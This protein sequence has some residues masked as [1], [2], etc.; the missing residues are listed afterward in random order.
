MKRIRRSGIIFR[1]AADLKVSHFRKLAALFSKTDCIC[2]IPVLFAS[3]SILAACSPYL[4]R[5]SAAVRTSHSI[6]TTTT[7]Q[8]DFKSSFRSVQPWSVPSSEQRSSLPASGC[9]RRRSPLRGCSKPSQPFAIAVSAASSPRS[10]RLQ[11]RKI[12]NSKASLHA[13]AA[14]GYPEGPPSA[15]V[16]S[17]FDVLPGRAKAHNK[18]GSYSS[19]AVD[20]KELGLH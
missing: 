11:T 6:L 20:V 18:F 2:W 14:T 10:P 3:L 7:I 8:P 19:V 9:Q 12:S 15:A 13:V 1:A 16:P 4:K 17:N 5:S